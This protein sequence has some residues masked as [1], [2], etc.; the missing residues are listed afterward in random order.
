M[1]EPQSGLATVDAVGI[2]DA[3]G[4]YNN[5]VVDLQCSA[6]RLNQ[7]VARMQRAQGA[8]L[9]VLGAFHD[10]RNLL[11]PI[12][13]IDE[14]IKPTDEDE[15]QFIQDIQSAAQRAL[16]LSNNIL[17]RQSGRSHAPALREAPAFLEQMIRQVR[18]FLRRDIQVRT[19]IEPGTVRVDAEDMLQV[20]H[21]LF[22]NAVAA[23][24]TGLVIDVWGAPLDGG[25]RIEVI[26]NGPGISDDVV[27]RV[28]SL[29]E[30]EDGTIHGLG[31]ALVAHLIQC[32]RGALRIQGSAQGTRVRLDL[33]CE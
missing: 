5:P 30:R 20:L 17:A 21:N 26:D 16:E 1:I 22:T 7:T 9:H 23:R 32:N 6:A 2:R 3:E 4:T 15:A 29:T 10:F 14:L 11:T 18:P 8:G 28:G 31:L 25:Y 13:L 24:D 33:P 12:L 27:R 19:F